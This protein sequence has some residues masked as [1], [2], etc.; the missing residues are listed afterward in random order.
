MWNN[1]RNRLRLFF[2]LTITLPVCLIS[3][4]NASLQLSLIEGDLRI[5]VACPSDKY[6]I[7]RISPKMDWEGFYERDL[8]LVTVSEKFPN[9]YLTYFVDGNVLRDPLVGEYVERIVKRS[10]CDQETSFVLIGKD[11]GVKR[12]W[13]GQLSITDLFQMIDAMPMRQYE[14]RTRGG[15]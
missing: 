1:V 8:E 7:D 9:V 14:M 6:A 3:S 15:N 10:K 13:T 4:A 5:L 2:A 11:G 12:R